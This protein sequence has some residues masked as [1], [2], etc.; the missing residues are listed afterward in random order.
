M[1]AQRGQQTR[2]ATVAVQKR[3][4]EHK[5]ELSDAADQDRVDTLHALQPAH[6]VGHQDGDVMGGRRRVHCLAGSS[7]HHVVLTLR[8]SPGAA[9]PPRTPTTSRLWISRMSPSVTGPPP[10]RYCETKSNASR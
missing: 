5:L 9:A 4:D 8:Y 10:C 7:I 6:Q 3:V 1:Q 2:G